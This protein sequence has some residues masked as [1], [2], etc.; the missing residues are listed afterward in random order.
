MKTS[1][2]VSR[3]KFFAGLGLSALGTV[4]LY[5]AY[6][7]SNPQVPEIQSSITTINRVGSETSAVAFHAETMLENL[8]I[9]WSLAFAPDGRMFFTER[10]GRINVVASGSS[11]PSLFSE[12]PVENDSE[13]GLLGLALSPEF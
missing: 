6:R 9:P 12:I 11:K 13:G 1:E 5:A 7:L 3:R 4:G 2:K 8:M 10:V